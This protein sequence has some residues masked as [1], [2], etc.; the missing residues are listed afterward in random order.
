MQESFV[1]ISDKAGLPPGSLVHVGD[2]LESRARVSLIDYSPRNF[3]EKQVHSIDEILDYK[4]RKTIT[5]VII[6]GLADVEIVGEIGKM[7]GIHPLVL[8][9]ILNTNQRPNSKDMTTIYF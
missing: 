7:F 9:D 3:E 5:W 6:E 1:K 2:V 4:D 8:E